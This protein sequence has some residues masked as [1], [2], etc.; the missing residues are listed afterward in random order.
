MH[1]SYWIPLQR[2]HLPNLNPE[3]SSRSCY[4]DNGD[5]IEARSHHVTPF[6]QPRYDTPDVGR[7]K[8][9]I[10]APPQEVLEH[11]ERYVQ[12]NLWPAS[13]GAKGKDAEPME[14]VSPPERQQ[15]NVS[16]SACKEVKENCNWQGSC[17]A[18]GS[19]GPRCSC[20]MGQSHRSPV[21][22]APLLCLN[23]C[24]GKGRCVRGVCVCERGFWGQDCSST[25]DANGRPA[26][27]DGGG[28]ELLVSNERE[29][30]FTPHTPP[31]RTHVPWCLNVSLN[32]HV[33]HALDD[34]S[35]LCH[36]SCS[37]SRLRRNRPLSSSTTCQRNSLHTRLRSSASTRISPA[38]TA[39]PGLITSPARATGRCAPMRLRDAAMRFRATNISER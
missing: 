31:L 8:H 26:V 7:Q 37:L 32:H 14:E 18:D 5:P 21:C 35:R 15:D 33:S 9:K 12:K 38:R 4:E 23:A 34:G 3:L 28:P 29:S 20:E 39:I 19:R 6:P 25:R 13:K 24:R 22:T 10:G 11:P 1:C 16:L 36:P 27:L 2:E 30:G 17:A